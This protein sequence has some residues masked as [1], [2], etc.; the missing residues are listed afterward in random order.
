MTDALTAL[1][2]TRPDFFQK[3]VFSILQKLRYGILTLQDGEKKFTFGN[4]AN[5]EL[6]ALITIRQADVY[7]N[8]LLHGALGA[9]KSYIA[10]HWEADDLT[11]LLHIFL[12]NR[13]L[14]ER[15][16]T[17]PAK[18]ANIFRRATQNWRSD[19]I[20]KSKKNILKHYDIGNHFFE[21][22]L[23]PL[24]MYSCA[25]FDSQK[26]TLEQASLN[27]LSII[28]DALQIQPEDHILE[29]GTGWGGFAFYVVKKYGCRVTTTTISD[30]QYRFVK[31]MTEKYGLED[32]IK[33]LKTD[34]RKLSGQYDKLV[35][36]EMIEAVGHSNLRNFFSQCNSLLKKN[37]LFFLQAIIIRD[38]YYNTARQ[39]IDFIK[40]FIFPGGCLPSTQIISNCIATET[41]MQLMNYRDI[42]KHYPATLQK[43]HDNFFSNLE[44]IQEIGF[45]DEFVRMWKYYFCY[46]SAGFSS[47][48]ISVM[49]GLWKK[50][51]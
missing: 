28:S 13:S 41:D 34:Y 39:E 6:S 27:K 5:G 38:K 14:I 20:S 30:K 16:E 35:S 26:K 37:G 1:P 51:N 10:G 47:R 4:K 32:K 25:I 19:S 12:E 40:K 43:W 11:K 31:A 33:L 7:R 36:I 44:R 3:I 42:G 17:F 21:L 50:I 9:S 48:N 29:I 15:L 22:F 46:C 2:D 23:D 24:M 45:S 18:I 49:Q 8:V